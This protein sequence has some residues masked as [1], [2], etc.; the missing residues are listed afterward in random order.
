MTEHEGWS[1]VPN[2]VIRSERLHGT[3]KLLYIALLNRANKRGECWP[4]L[5]TLCTDVDVS[6]RT[7]IEKMKRL[8]SLGLVQKVNRKDGDGAATNNLYRVS[9]WEG[10]ADSALGSANGNQ[11]VVQSST[12]GSANGTLEVLPNEVLPNQVL[13]RAFDDAWASWPKRDKKKPALTKFVKLAKQ[14]PAE[15]LAEQI[16]KFGDAYAVSTEPQYVPAL[17]VWLN[18][19]RWTD[20]LPARVQE[21]PAPVTV[22]YDWMNR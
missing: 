14:H 2:W 20:P 13:E 19:E 9:T 1:V 21:K 16:K 17:V 18:Q 6:R 22:D 5:S 4:S 10:G 7:V 3:E 12:G 11:G 8:E 15:W